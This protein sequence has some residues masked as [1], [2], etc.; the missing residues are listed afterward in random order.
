M[1]RWKSSLFLQN[2]IRAL[3]Y[4]FAGSSADALNGTNPKLGTPFA[5]SNLNKL[6][7]VAD[8]PLSITHW[9]Y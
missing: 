6:T 5:L 2:L 3:T 7:S 4:V 9:E 8:K 1:Q